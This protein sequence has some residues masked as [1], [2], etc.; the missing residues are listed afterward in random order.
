MTRE[1]Q[2]QPS[3]PKPDLKM[4]PIG[5]YLFGQC[6]II[7]DVYMKANGIKQTA[8]SSDSIE[9]VLTDVEG[10]GILKS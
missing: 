5:A 4:S 8:P 1:E 10:K 3:Q 6:K 7:N 2:P 9:D